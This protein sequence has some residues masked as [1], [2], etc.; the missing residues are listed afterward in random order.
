MSKNRFIRRVAVM[1]SCALVMSFGFGP[2]ASSH[3]GSSH[4]QVI[5][6]F[7]DVTSATLIGATGNVL[8]C[9]DAAVTGIGPAGALA[10]VFLSGYDSSK[11][12][13]PAAITLDPNP[14]CV[15][16][17]YG[18]TA[19]VN[20]ERAQAT[21][22]EIRG[23]DTG[24]AVN[25]VTGA[26]G[27]VNSTGA[28]LLQGGVATA[29]RD[30]LDAPEV[31]SVT[32]V[33]GGGA[34]DFTFDKVLDGDVAT[35]ADLAAAD[36]GYQDATGAIFRG[37]GTLTAGAPD[38]A[39]A[40]VR[41]PFTT[42]GDDTGNAVRFFVDTI[43][44]GGGPCLGS[45]YD[46]AVW[47]RGTAPTPGGVNLNAKFN[48]LGTIL[49]GSGSTAFPDPTAI[50]EAPPNA[51]D[52]TFDEGP[53]IAPGSLNPACV[54]AHEADGDVHVATAAALLN[55]AGGANQVRYTFGAGPASV[56]VDQIQVVGLF[57]GAAI[58]S[59]LEP[60][61]YMAFELSDRL[62]A[63]Y[64]DSSDLEQATKDTTNN[65]VTYCGDIDDDLD[66]G[67]LGAAPAPALHYVQDST[68]ATVT[69]GT[70]VV[71]TS[72]NC[73]TIQFP[74][75]V[76]GP[77]VAAGALF[78]AV[79]DDVPVATT[80]NLNTVAGSPATLGAGDNPNP[81][82]LSAVQIGGPPPTGAPGAPTPPPPPPPTTPPGPP[83]VTTG[84][85]D[86]TR[87]T[88]AQAEILIGTAGPD[89]ICGFGG[90]DLLRMRGGGDQGRGG[91]GDDTIAGQ[92]GKDTARGG[93]GDDILR[94]GAGNDNLRGGAGDDTGAG[95]KGND[96]IRGGKGDDTAR[97]GKGK[98]D[99]CRAEVQKGCER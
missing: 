24:G 20:Q 14:N 63:G 45:P 83:T 18:T 27:A 28:V 64:S 80:G 34:A 46:N 49:V 43:H 99:L 47:D 17:D 29:D 76:V 93:P 74:A 3:T 70:G 59:A 81:S 65:R 73:R 96:T 38:F 1:A 78:G 79:A 82:P 58:N 7:L 13:N 8:T 95:G 56:P 62:E 66:T 90:D 94:G 98:R 37:D 54:I 21:T 40:T 55:P 97:G 11:F 26:G 72:G 51:V 12:D 77:A 48:G 32:P 50:A 35:P 87:A 60:S 89:N 53:L 75:G 19:A 61:T 41:V 71:G 88:A 31:Q 67:T 16:M 57:P 33:A 69:V 9:F 86:A 85:C 91:P 44:A 68:G 5:T 30:H 36:F 22:L 15:N 23:T 10:Q 42:A 84:L 4:S 25:V 92:K 6:D 39:G 2:S 52:V